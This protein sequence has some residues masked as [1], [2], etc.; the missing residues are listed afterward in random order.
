MASS[1][2]ILSVQGDDPLQDYIN[3]IEDNY[4][5]AL[6]YIQELE[7]EDEQEAHDHAMTKGT[8][9]TKT[10]IQTEMGGGFWEPFAGI[11]KG[12]EDVFRIKARMKDK[13]SGY[14]AYQEKNAAGA[15][16]AH[17]FILYDIF[18]KNFGLLSF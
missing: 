6:I 5:K 4:N 18:K 17:V 10:Y 7:D 9:Y 12:F 2:P 16:R 14:E 8:H 11:G 3:R 15:V 13:W 1:N